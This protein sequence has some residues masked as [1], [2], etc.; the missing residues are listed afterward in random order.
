M[1]PDDS[2][3]TYRLVGKTLDNGIETSCV[4]WTG[5]TEQTARD[6]LDETGVKRDSPAVD[7]AI[8]FLEQLLENGPV[9]A[10]TVETEIK[11]AGHASRTVQRAKAEL[12]IKSKNRGQFYGNEWWWMTPEQ[13][14]EDGLDSLPEN[15]GSGGHRQQ[16]C[17]GELLENEPENESKNNLK[18]NTG[19]V[20]SNTEGSSPSNDGQFPGGELLQEA[21]NT[22]RNASNFSPE[23]DETEFL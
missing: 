11:A 16:V 1:S 2:G 17:A 20:L 5:H 4:E 10:K 14:A 21:E 19:N 13:L 22:R 12:G 3:L 18:A 6:A 23:N 9:T 7:D 15:A 8:Y